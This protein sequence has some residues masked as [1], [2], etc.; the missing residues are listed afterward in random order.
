MNDKKT[1]RAIDIINLVGSILGLVSGLL[2]S[3]LGVKN[4]TSN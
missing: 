4:G 1:N 3:W 2:K